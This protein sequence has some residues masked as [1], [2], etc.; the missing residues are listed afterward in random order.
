[1]SQKLSHFLFPGQG[2]RNTPVTCATGIIELV[3]L[4]PGRLAS[5][6]RRQAS[7][8]LCRYLGGDISLVDEICALRGFQGQMAVQKPE[9]PRRIFGEVV[10]ATAGGSQLAQVLYNM[11]ER[12]TKQEQMLAHIHERLEH[13]RQRVNLNVR[14]PKRAAPHQPQ[15]ARE[16]TSSI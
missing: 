3:M 10:E 16:D 6:V 9:D 12:L 4:L 13:G 2:Q 14:A 1:M 11:S 15:I 8:L 5:R 7:E